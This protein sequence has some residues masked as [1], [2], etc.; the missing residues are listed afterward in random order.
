MNRGVPPTAVKARTGEF[1]P[2]GMTAQAS[3]NSCA[4]VR[5]RASAWSV[6]PMPTSVP[7]F[8]TRSTTGCKSWSCNFRSG[9]LSSTGHATNP[10]QLIWA[11]WAPMFAIIEH[12]GRRSG[13]TYRTPVTVFKAEV[14]GKPGLAVLLAYR[15]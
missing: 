8:S 3:S 5:T 10:I 11:G 12:V 9:W 4:E 7:A 15:S 6:L 2:P 1:T 13:K 14:D